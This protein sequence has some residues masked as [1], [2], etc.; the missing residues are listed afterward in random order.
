M[1]TPTEKYAQRNIAL[2]KFKGVPRSQERWKDALS[3]FPTLQQPFTQTKHGKNSLRSTA[4]NSEAAVETP[5]N[6]DKNHQSLNIGF[7][8]MMI[9][10]NHHVEAL[11]EAQTVNSKN[12]ENSLQVFCI[13]MQR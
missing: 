11:G 2:Q 7:Q 5:V 4:V 9:L 12:E 6:R 1:L 8:I 13:L 3:Q 10:S